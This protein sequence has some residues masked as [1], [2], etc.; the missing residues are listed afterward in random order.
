[1]K[2]FTTSIAFAVILIVMTVCTWIRC[3]VQAIIN[4]VTNGGRS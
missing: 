3:G 4:A 1:M 2:E